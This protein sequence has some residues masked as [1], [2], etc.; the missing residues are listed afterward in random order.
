MLSVSVCLATDERTLY[1]ALFGTS[2]G[3]TTKV[4]PIKSANKPLHVYVEFELNQIQ[5]LVS[6]I[7][8][9]S[10]VSNSS[11]RLLLIEMTIINIF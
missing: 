1:N 2:S 5:E 7:K 10:L 11:Q 4:R 9:S 3:Y 8:Y 6:M